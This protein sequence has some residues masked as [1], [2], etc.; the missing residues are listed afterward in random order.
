MIKRAV[1]G[2]VAC[3]LAL[4]VLVTPVAGAD[5]M[6]PPEVA[7]EES[8]PSP[9]I[10]LADEQGIAAEEVT[11]P[12]MLTPLAS[13]TEVIQL[14][15]DPPLGL[16]PLVIHRVTAGGAGGSNASYDYVELYNPNPHDVFV[17]SWRL[18]VARNART[19]SRQEFVIKGTVRAKSYI[20][21]AGADKTWFDAAE[22]DF[23]LKSDVSMIY[24]DGRVR[25]S[26]T[27]GK[28]ID[29][30]AWGNGVTDATVSK[31]NAGEML[32]HV[33]TPEGIPMMLGESRT[34]FALKP[35]V[36]IQMPREVSYQPYAEPINR[37]SG[38]MI[39]EIAA[40]TAAEKQF[41]ELHNPTS[42][43]LI[44]DGCLLQ[45][46]RSTTK[47]HTLTGVMQP[48]EYKQLPLSSTGLT[49]TKTTSG[50]VYILSSDGKE[51]TDARSYDG[52]AAESSWAWFGGDD[53][54][55]T[56]APTPG[57]ANSW[58][59]FLPCSVGYERNGETGRCRKIVIEESPTDCGPGKY[60]NPETNRCRTIE[61]AS[62]LTPCKEG[63]YRSPETNRCRS[64][65]LAT[66]TPTPCKP[67]QERNP[68]TNRCRKKAAVGIPES[69]FAVEPMKE[70][71]K[72]FVGW[73]ALGGIGTLAIG[74]GA[75]EWRNE[76]LTGIRKVISFLTS[77]K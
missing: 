61:L 72:A 73:W 24:D 54:R 33:Y 27:A 67:D 22:P 65:A 64:V 57:A 12:A 28:V 10:E 25:L 26:N 21:I 1:L 20:L 7:A 39:S 48:G 36:R 58:Q 34:I 4:H 76:M 49:L 75:W 15:E 38:L 45:T 23:R 63:Q 50:V 71:G 14:A 77:G 74:R 9:S 18:T 66:N 6:P 46:N 37:C 5:E 43:P 35:A 44:M 59:E 70:T 52:L 56:F 30:V 40:N 51:E 2:I 32:E 47:N 3:I 19:D 29:E 11:A 62:V 13:P 17:D 8:I 55:Q 53:W 69:A 68:E 41:I 42:L 60:R 16:P 31:L